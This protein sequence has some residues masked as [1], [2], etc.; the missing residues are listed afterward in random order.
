MKLYLDGVLVGSN[1]YTG[2]LI[3]NQQPIVIGGSNGTNTDDSGNLS[4][5]KISDPFDGHIDE[6]S[7]YGAALSAEQIAQTRGRGAKGIVAPGD[8]DTLEAANRISI[9]RITFADGMVVNVA[10]GSVAFGGW[11]WRSV[12]DAVNRIIERIT[13]ADGMVVNVAPGSGSVQISPSAGGARLGTLAAWSWTSVMGSGSDGSS[14]SA[15]PAAEETHD[16]V[17]DLADRRGDEGFDASG[18]FAGTL[19][20]FSV[21]GVAFGNDH[22]DGHYDGRGEHRH[23]GDDGAFGANKG[24][25][26]S[27]RNAK[28][29]EH[30]SG[31]G[32]GQPEPKQAVNWN[33]SFAG[34][35]A[36]FSSLGKSRGGA[37]PNICEFDQ[38]KSRKNSYR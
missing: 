15:R 17:S 32:S 21:D 29:S 12:L 30:E 27:G 14:E 31:L 3:G 10:P 35:V 23:D 18:H 25:D 6:V 1:S 22:G 38:Q 26:G 28:A 37:N 4:K 33:D 24:K 36:P 13:F 11:I 16:R 34:L 19:A 5:L 9:E 20:L 8:L 7:F 2:G